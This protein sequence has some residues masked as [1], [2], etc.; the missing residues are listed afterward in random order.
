MFQ[1]IFHPSVSET[2]KCKV[3]AFLDEWNNDSLEIQAV[4]S[5]STGKP[6]SIKLAKAQ[7]RASAKMTGSFFNSSPL[8]KLLLCLS[9][10]YI[11]GK[12]M[13]VRAIEW[14]ACLYVVEPNAPTLIFEQQMKIDFAAM[15]PYQLEKY[16]IE[17]TSQ[18]ISISTILIGGMATSH[19]LE[20]KIRT[21]GLTVFL[22]FGMTETTSHIALKSLTQENQP[23]QAVGK[24]TFSV[25]E[26][27]QLTIHAPDL[28]IGRL[29][30]NDAVQLLSSTSFFWK[31]RLDN[32]INSGGVKF[33]AEE[34]ESKLQQVLKCRF[35]IFAQTDKKY[36]DVVAICIEAEENTIN[37]AELR[38]LLPQYAYPK[39]WYFSTQFAE[40]PNGKVDRINTLNQVECEKK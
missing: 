10:D 38:I 28:G 31:G 7:M 2:F 24:T 40:T 11:A 13:L 26:M 32:V 14:E 33:Y 25:N 22:S 35:F 17:L 19:T 20:E 18:Q 39:K 36:G 15:M 21:Q 5:G 16:F 30:T 23:Y 4:T 34:L 37:K 6:K 1:L 27:N 29:I 9:P 3:Y 12:M 8:N